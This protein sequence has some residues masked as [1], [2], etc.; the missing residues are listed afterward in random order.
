MLEKEISNFKQESFKTENNPYG[1][2]GHWC[3]KQHS[4]V[5]V[6]IKLSFIYIQLTQLVFFEGGDVISSMPIQSIPVQSNLELGV[7]M[8]QL[9]QVE[10]G[11]RRS[12]EHILAISYEIVVYMSIR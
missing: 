9:Y 6:T 12:S 7:E 11:E 8:L 2:S 3:D 4:K 1:D 5:F 10:R